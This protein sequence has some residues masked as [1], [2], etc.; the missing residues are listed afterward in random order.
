MKKSVKV[1][2]IGVLLLALVIAYIARLQAV[3]AEFHDTAV[4][5]YRM[6]EEVAFGTDILMDGT[7][8]GYTITVNRAEVLTYS[9]FLEKY[10]LPDIYSYVP[11]KVYDVDV[12]IKNKGA[13]PSAGIN[14]LSFYVQGIAVCG[15]L[16]TNLFDEVNPDLEG[17][18]AIAL[19]DNSEIELHLPFGL[20]EY[21]FR[22]DIWNDL[23]DF[24]M[25]F[26][27]TLYPNKKIVHLWN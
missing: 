23:D 20:W 27:A 11:D 7:M 13:D 6:G 24:K 10:Q 9:E 19:R 5:S 18:Y 16:N 2:L 26:V 14:L 22:T 3:N 4:I 12:T 8:E 1:I 15:G 25:D 17:I 21:S